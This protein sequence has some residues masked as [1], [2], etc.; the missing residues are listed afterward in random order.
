VEDRDGSARPALVPGRM[1]S[2]SHGEEAAMGGVR[3]A[4]RVVPAEHPQWKTG[5]AVRGRLALPVHW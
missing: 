3:A 1:V 4:G 2:R 5:M